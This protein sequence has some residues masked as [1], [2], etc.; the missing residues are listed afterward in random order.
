MIDFILNIDEH[1]NSIIQTY[2]ALSYLILFLIVFAE[3][4]FVV[5]PFLPGDSL[6]FVAGAFAAKGSLQISLLLLILIF[7][8]ILGD[9]IN[10]FTGHYFGEKAYKSRFIKKEHIQRTENFFKKYGKKTIIIARFVPIV[11]TLA[12]FVA[13][14]GKMHYSTF[15]AYN[16]CGGIFWVSL[17][18]L[19]GYFFGNVPAVEEHF[20]LVIF[21]IIF[22]SIMPPAYEYTKGK[23]KRKN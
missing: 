7:A 6:L 15:A 2:G 22:L 16:I 20:T 18:S 1:L 14:V 4:G 9:T 8:A 3:T 11:R 5:T 23:Y 21:F 17:F 12:P 10:Y 19:A 13:G